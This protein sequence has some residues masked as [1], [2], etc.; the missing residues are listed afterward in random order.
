MKKT[1]WVVVC[2]V[3]GTL[4]LTAG[5]AAA[6]WTLGARAGAEADAAAAEIDTRAYKYL[7]LDKVIVMLRKA[8][9]EV[10][11]H[12]LAVDLVLKTPNE[13]ERVARDHLPLLRS[14]T[15]KA[16]SNIT[17]EEASRASVDDLTSLINAAFVQ[18]YANDREGKPF[19]E[20]LIGK[21]II[22]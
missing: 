18:T 22:E 14:V 6:F 10:A 21:L 4:A 20:A 3:A 12:Y 9:G 16:L 13:A 17:M 7:N 2:L 11:S 1:K 8:D 5:A 19:T 15:V